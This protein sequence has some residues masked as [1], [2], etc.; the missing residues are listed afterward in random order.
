MCYL[1]LDITNVGL[2]CI[3]NI[4]VNIESDVFKETKYLIDDKKQRI[5]KKR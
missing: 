5:L 4:V 2:G 1:N 3:K